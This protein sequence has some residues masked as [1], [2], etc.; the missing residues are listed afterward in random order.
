MSGGGARCGKCGYEIGELGQARG[1]ILDR[2]SDSWTCDACVAGRPH[3][4]AERLEAEIARADAL[5]GAARAMGW[6]AIGFS[7]AWLAIAAALV[8]VVVKLARA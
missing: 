8:A 1:W 2:A 5:S 3:R 7:I 6:A 4:A